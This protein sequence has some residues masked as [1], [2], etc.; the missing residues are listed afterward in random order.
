MGTNESS[1]PRPLLLPD[2]SCSSA[3]D[4][5]EV[6][7]WEKKVPATLPWPLTPPFSDPN[8]LREQNIESQE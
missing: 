3:Q 6:L 5:R 7:D 2:G 4:K 1:L 8:L